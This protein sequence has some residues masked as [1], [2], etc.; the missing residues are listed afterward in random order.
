MG[1]DQGI[2]VL[3]FLVLFLSPL[4]FVEE[5]RC[6]PMDSLRALGG[7]QGKVGEILLG[8][9]TAHMN[10]PTAYSVAHQHKPASGS[11]I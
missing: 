6:V 9:P 7:G 4:T 3:F 2:S 5:D 8:P 10:K 11:R 1:K